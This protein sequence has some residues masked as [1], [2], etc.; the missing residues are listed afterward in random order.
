VPV[1]MGTQSMSPA[2]RTLE[3]WLLAHKL[4]HGMHPVLTM[5]MAN[6]VVSSPDASNRKLDKKKSTGRIDGAVALAT[7][8]AVAG[9]TKPKEKRDYK[10]RLI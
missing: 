5:C 6:A 10:V 9:E 3:G 1:G 7:A 2:L 8:A 4:A